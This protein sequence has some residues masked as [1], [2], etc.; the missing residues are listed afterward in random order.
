MAA[1]VY[2]R[3]VRFDEIDAAGLVYFPKVVALAHEGLERM[4]AE[5]MPG[6]YA[7]LVVGR[8]IGLPCVHFEADFKAPLRF[9][10]DVRV[11]VTVGE[12][13]SS[14]VKLDVVVARTDGVHCAQLFYVTAC[15]ALDGPKK[16]PLPDDLRAVLERY[17]AT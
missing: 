10:D 15:A 9:G 16:L 4:L 3:A 6:G 1:F 17:R 11:T 5:G 2:T 12:L 8:R 14:S 13:G 7:A